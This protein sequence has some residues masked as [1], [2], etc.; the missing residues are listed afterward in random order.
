LHVLKNQAIQSF[1]SLTLSY[2]N[3]QTSNAHSY[4]EKDG[5]LFE[6]HQTTKQAF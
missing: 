2:Q 3:G 5:I 1:F 4:F 6:A